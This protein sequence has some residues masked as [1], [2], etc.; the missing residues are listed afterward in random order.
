MNTHFCE[1]FFDK[2]EEREYTIVLYIYR[3]MANFFTEMFTGKK[4]EEEDEKS[5]KDLMK[6]QQGNWKEKYDIWRASLELNSLKLEITEAEEKDTLNNKKLVFSQKL[7][8]LRTWIMTDL[9]PKEKL[10]F[11]EK[12]NEIRLVLYLGKEEA[13]K[14]TKELKEEWDEL[15]KNIHSAELMEKVINDITHAET[16]KE[17]IKEKV[18]MIIDYEQALVWLKFMEMRKNPLDLV[19]DLGVGLIPAYG[20][21]ISAWTSIVVTD[22][23][24]RNIPVWRWERVRYHGK[25]WV[26]FWVWLTPAAWDIA[27]ALINPNRDFAE[28]CH[29]AVENMR[30]KLEETWL[31][32][33]ATAI[34]KA[35]VKELSRRKKF[36]MNSILKKAWSKLNKKGETSNENTKS[37]PINTNS[38]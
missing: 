15:R 25:V 13:E 17:N 21:I 20:D 19:V 4:K 31:G 30:T 10:Q 14:L 26:D 12:L 18:Q 3:L 38:D 6:E 22:Y 23:I 5:N 27:D 24:T 2:R 16:D 8:S 32:D 37:V 1:C 35:Y 33:A 34:E 29:E 9:D 11:L 28:V 36:F 7:D